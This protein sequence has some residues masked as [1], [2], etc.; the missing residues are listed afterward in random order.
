MEQSAFG[1]QM[2]QGGMAPAMGGA[3]APPGLPGGGAG[4]VDP[5]TAGMAGQPAAGVDPATGQSMMA[6]PVTQ[7][8]NSGGLATTPDEMMAQAE[9]I[10]QELLGLPEGQ[11][12]SELRALKQ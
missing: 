10:A 5:A 9:A 8:V 7:M 11:K 4:G 3:P 12:D 2:A 1:Q 6:G